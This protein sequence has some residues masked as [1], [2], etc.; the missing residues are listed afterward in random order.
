MKLT[1]LGSDLSAEFSPSSL[2]MTNFHEIYMRKGELEQ[3]S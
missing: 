1:L 2:I 3:A